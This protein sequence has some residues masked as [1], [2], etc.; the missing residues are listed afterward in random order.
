[1]SLQLTC[2]RNYKETAKTERYNVLVIL[3]HPDP[4]ESFNASIADEVVEALGD[5]GHNTRVLSIGSGEFDPVISK[6]ELVTMYA[7]PGI[8][9]DLKTHIDSVKWANAIVYIYPTWWQNVPAALKG[10]VDRVLLPSI[11]FAPPTGKSE[12]IRPLLN[13]KATAVITTTGGPA[14]QEPD[15]GTSFLT[16]VIPTSCYKNG[17]GDILVCKLH[18]VL[19]KAPHLS[20]LLKS[21]YNEIRNF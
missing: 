14:G 11:A 21:V 13:I 1:M 9:A 10:W 18:S 2:S 3:A 6:E 16:D 12:S 17:V 8:S 20:D 5:A 7:S 19:P 4:Q 15:L